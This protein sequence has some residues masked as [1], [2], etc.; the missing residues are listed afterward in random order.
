MNK[1]LYKKMKT[2]NLN[3]T[4]IKMNTQQ[5]ESLLINLPVVKQPKK[6]G[7]GLK[8]VPVNSVS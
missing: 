7:Y 5:G 3:Q 8:R 1:K 2:K 6:V 4:K